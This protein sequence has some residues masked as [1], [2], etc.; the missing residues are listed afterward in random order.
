M[1][2]PN[3][4]ATDDL[5][6]LL[7][8]TTLIG[9]SLA[10]IDTLFDYAGV[11]ASAVA[12]WELDTGY[13]PFIG[14][15]DTRLFDPPGPEQGPVGVYLGLNNVGGGRKLFVQT[16]LISINAVTILIS[17]ANPTGTVV[18]VND[19]FYLRP[20]AAPQY[21]R[22]Y[23]YLEF[24]VPQYGLPS[25]IQIN[26]VFGYALQWP[27]DAWQAVLRKAASELLPEFQL[28]L[29][30][31]VLSIKEQDES[32]QYAQSPLRPTLELWEAAYQKTLGR[33]ARRTL[34]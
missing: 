33:Y 34:F 22:P 15:A 4:P 8:T 7:Q 21:G 32:V 28:M 11:L 3:A 31:G 30:R 18:N 14:A 17:A 6:A 13:V 16:G 25:S 12:Q 1:P 19:D 9:S 29:H 27:D 26:G 24:R 5:I 23:T 20:Q 2:K 10:D